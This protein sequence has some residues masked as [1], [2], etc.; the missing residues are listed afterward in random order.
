MIT[1]ILREAVKE[2]KIESSSDSTEIKKAAISPFLVYLAFN[3]LL[4]LMLMIAIVELFLY[5]A[6]DLLLT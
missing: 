1:K 6:I 5:F 4:P 2:L 3:V